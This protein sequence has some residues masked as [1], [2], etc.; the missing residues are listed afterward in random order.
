MPATNQK[1]AQGAESR[2]RLLQ[3]AADLVG[4]GGYS[5]TSVD[6]IAKH[7]GVV[8][9]ALYWHFGNKNGLLMAALETY[10]GD[11]VTDVVAAVADATDPI[12]RLDR[13]LHHVRELI[14]ER[15][16]SRRMVFSLLLERGQHDPECQRVIADLFRDMRDAL[17]TGF[18]QVLPTVTAERLEIITDCLVAQLD[19]LF[20]RFIAEPNVARLDAQLAEVRRATILRLTH[21]IQKSLRG[22]S[23]PSSD[24][25]LS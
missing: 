10:T 9:S 5:R 17:N 13:L 22:K 6:A 2:K 14:V 21:E 16:L 1:K 8:K 24:P 3:A 20:L 12:L 7:A 18:A 25:S 19:G 15:P 23:Q 11:W 4:T